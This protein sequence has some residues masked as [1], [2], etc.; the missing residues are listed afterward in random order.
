MRE[1]AGAGM[2]AVYR[3]YPEKESLFEAAFPPAGQGP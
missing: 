2:T 1:T 3:Y